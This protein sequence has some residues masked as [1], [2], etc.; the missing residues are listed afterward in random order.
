MDANRTRAK[1]AQVKWHGHRLASWR[2]ANYATTTS[3]SISLSIRTHE[4]L[5]NSTSS[6]GG[7][8]IQHV[9]PW[10]SVE[11]LDIDMSGGRLSVIDWREAR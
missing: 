1:V 4:T 5:V 10:S 8:E 2:P 6:F 9:N 11:V 7:G 3:G